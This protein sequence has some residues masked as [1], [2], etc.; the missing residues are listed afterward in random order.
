VA[1]GHRSGYCWPPPGRGTPP[2]PF[3]VNCR[4]RRS[5]LR[6]MTL[7]PLKTH[8]CNPSTLLR[9]PGRLVTDLT[10]SPDRCIQ[11][12]PGRL[13]PVTPD[14]RSL[15]GQTADRRFPIALHHNP[16][17]HFQPDDRAAR[18]A[19]RHRCP[20]AQV[21]SHRAAAAGISLART[22][23]RP[24]PS[25]VPALP[26]QLNCHNSPILTESTWEAIAWGVGNSGST[27]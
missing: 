26:S 2:G 16:H 11:V 14:A 27:C 25:V 1:R 6:G 20:A 7:A 13:N 15:A 21:A 8:P 18:L 9:Y 22:R 4:L 5:P 19:P 12:A 17:A 10:I 23:Y 3:R 24:E